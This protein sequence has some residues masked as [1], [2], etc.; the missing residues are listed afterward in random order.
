MGDEPQRRGMMR[1]IRMADQW[2]P[3][4][5]AIAIAEII[6]IHGPKRGTQIV[7]ALDDGRHDDAIHLAL[8]SGFDEERDG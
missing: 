4:G 6:R 1:E 7:Q 2:G 3:Q 8:S 5:R